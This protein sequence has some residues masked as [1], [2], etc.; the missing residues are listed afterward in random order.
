MDKEKKHTY[1]Y[2][3]LGL[4]P[5]KMVLV[6]AENERKNETAQ[7]ILESPEAKEKRERQQAIRK[8]IKHL[9]GE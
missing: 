5:L 4:P 2:D 8:L 9:N 1:Q 7:T 6:H 3:T